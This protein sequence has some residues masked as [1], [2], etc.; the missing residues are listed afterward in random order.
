MPRDYVYSDITSLCPWSIISIIFL[1]NMMCKT[2]IICKTV[3]LV[4]AKE[5]EGQIHRLIDSSRCSPNL[6]VAPI[7]FLFSNL[8]PKE[9]E[10]ESTLCFLVGGLIAALPLYLL[11]S[12]RPA[13]IKTVHSFSSDYRT[14]YTKLLN[15]KVRFHTWLRD[16]QTSLL[17]ALQG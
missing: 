12:F 2:Y 11:F 15:K 13:D 3:I 16:R 7:H 1:L 10:A 14:L 6:Q 9:E 8:S 4:C 5:I 17:V